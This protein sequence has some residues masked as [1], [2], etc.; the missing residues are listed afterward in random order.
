MIMNRS[1]FILSAY[2]IVNSCSQKKLETIVFNSPE[3]PNYKLIGEQ[4]GYGLFDK[5]LHVFG[6][7]FELVALSDSLPPF[8]LMT[9]S[10]SNN[11]ILSDTTFGIGQACD[12]NFLSQKRLNKYDTLKLS[13]FIG[14]RKPMN[15]KK[16][17]DLDL[18]LLIIDT[19]QL[20][21]SDSVGR[22][23]WFNKQLDSL[24]NVPQNQC[25]SNNLKLKKMDSTITNFM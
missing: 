21:Y 15:N 6:M 11:T 22:R 3:H 1:F 13:T 10:W 7:N 12:V 8:Y 5:D 17:F 20:N 9:C 23:N 18:A 24:K 19:V 25:W 4:Y 16:V 2:I 14:T